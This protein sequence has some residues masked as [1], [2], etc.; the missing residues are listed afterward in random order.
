MRNEVVFEMFTVPVYKDGAT[1]GEFAAC[2]RF[3][4]A[5]I[6]SRANFDACFSSTIHIQT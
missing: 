3:L 2:V 6:F 5:Y 1:G 4:L